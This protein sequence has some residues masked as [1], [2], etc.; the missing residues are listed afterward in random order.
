MRAR[1][2]GM[3]S[4]HGMRGWALLQHGRAGTPA[5]IL[6]SR[7][8]IQSLQLCLGRCRRMQDEHT[9]AGA[10]GCMKQQERMNARMHQTTRV[11]KYAHTSSTHTHT[12]HTRTHTHAHTHTIHK[13]THT[14]HTDTHA[15]MLAA[16]TG[17]ASA[18]HP[19]SSSS[20][21]AHAFPL[22]P[23]PRPR[24]AMEAPRGLEGGVVDVFSK[25]RQRTICVWLC[26]GRVL[27]AQAGSAR[28][29]QG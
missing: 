13:H 19:P 5:T 29:V 9:N 24:S 2:E 12:Q 3:G 26:G 20:P 18:S 10:H 22:D 11:H 1:D 21:T 17:P 28:S 15:R 14:T 27:K 4:G 6:S 16:R 25:R 8:S 23:G 7:S